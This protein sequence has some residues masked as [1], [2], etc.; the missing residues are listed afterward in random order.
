MIK[1]TIV[2]DNQIASP[3]SPIEFVKKY[4]L[5]VTGIEDL[6]SVTVEQGDWK[7]DDGEF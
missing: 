1:A 2:F 6:K 4:Y 5:S 7:I 3:F